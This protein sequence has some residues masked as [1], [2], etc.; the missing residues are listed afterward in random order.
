MGVDTGAG[1]GEAEGGVGVW[2][3]GAALRG[4]LPRPPYTSALRP[5]PLLDHAP[6]PEVVVIKNN[7]SGV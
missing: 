6:P 5:L 1:V 7:A 3:R 4:K 2:A